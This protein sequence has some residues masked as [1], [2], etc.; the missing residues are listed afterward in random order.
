MVSEPDP[1][2]RVT[3][4]TPVYTHDGEKL[5]TVKEVRAKAFKVGT[6]LFQKDYWLAGDSVAEAAPDV[7]VTLRVNKDQIDAQK[8]DEPQAV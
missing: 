1:I 6:G 8:I 3:V 5:G 4:E 7:A 2:L